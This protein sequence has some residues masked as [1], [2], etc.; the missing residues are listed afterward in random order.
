[1]MKRKPTKLLIAALLILF[2]GAVAK[3]QSKTW[4]LQECI[5]YALAQN[6]QVKKAGLSN[7][8][9][10]V[11]AEQAQASRL[12]LLNASVRENVNWPGFDSYTDTYG[13]NSGANSTNYSLS[14]SVSLFN[15]QKLPNKIKFNRV[16]WSVVRLV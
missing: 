7:D 10:K 3:A 1:M 11:Y 6:I 16:Y 2:S 13:S 15:G 14:S 4:T 5:N 9:F 8:R 12:P